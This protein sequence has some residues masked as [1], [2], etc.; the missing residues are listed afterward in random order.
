[1]AVAAGPPAS[2]STTKLPNIDSAQQRTCQKG[3]TAARRREGACNCR[4][5]LFTGQLT[6]TARGRMVFRY[7]Q[8]GPGFDRNLFTAAAV[9]ASIDYIHKQSGRPRAMQESPRLAV[10]ERPV[11]RV[12]RQPG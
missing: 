11:L 4:A 3:R 10:V 1:M 2:P 12:G 8:K 7:W 9:Q 5:I 6:T